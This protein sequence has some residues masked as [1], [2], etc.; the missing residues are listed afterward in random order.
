MLKKIDVGLSILMFSLFI[1]FP[2]SVVAEES[3][4]EYTTD[5]LM[6]EELIENELE[7]VD[8]QDGM[9]TSLEELL[10][11]WEMNGYPDNVGS[12]YYDSDSDKY[13]ISLI[14][15][16]EASRNE[17]RALLSDPDFNDFAKTTYSYNDLLTVQHEIENEMEAQ[18]SEIYSIG[19]GWTVID[20]ELTGFG[21]SGKEFRVVVGVD[22]SVFAE[23]SQKYE[24]LYGDMVYVEIDSLG[25]LYIADDVKNIA[26]QTKNNMWLY[27]SFIAILC[28]AILAGV[29]LKRNGLLVVKQTT[30]GDLV[31]DSKPLRKNEVIS[32]IRASDIEPGD[33][34]F[35]AI[36]KKIDE[37]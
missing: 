11:D 10:S 23:Y 18:N 33:H 20:G 17:I 4:A 22:E 12:V 30:N 9:N 15:D 31:T 21:D 5:T 19:T 28:I 29:L 25:S 27:A 2:L 14:N 1:S 37:Q 35:D 6:D 36:K 7:V 34:V 32:S 13:I 24:K 16:D 8:S 26:E 3:P